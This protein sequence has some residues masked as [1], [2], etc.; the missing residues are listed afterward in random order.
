[1]R[2]KKQREEQK[3]REKGQE[4]SGVESP[5]MG[6][7]AALFAS[8][9]SV[10]DVSL[11]GTESP[12]VR[13][14][15]GLPG[16]AEAA[17]DVEVEVAQ[18]KD[19]SER[20]KDGKPGPESALVSSSPPVAVPA[21]ETETAADEK[22]EPVGAM[23]VDGKMEVATT[24]ADGDVKMDEAQVQSHDAVD[25][26][27][28]LV[29]DRNATPDHSLSAAAHEP[30][31]SA[32][33]PEYASEFN[34]RDVLSPS[35]PTPNG[36]VRHRSPSPDYHRRSRTPPRVLNGYAKTFEA[37]V[38]LLDAVPTGLVAPARED[39]D[40]PVDTRSQRVAS[41][42]P[43]T[44]RTSPKM[45][46][47][48]IPL[49]SH[50]SQEDGEILSPPPPKSLSLAPPR[51]HSPPTHPR[52]FYSSGGLSP[53]RPSPGSLSQSSARAPLHPAYLARNSPASVS[54]LPPPAPPS[55]PRALRQAGGYSGSSYLGSGGQNAPYY[56]PP[57]PRG[58]SADRD[59][60]RDRARDWGRD[61]DRDVDRVWHP[62]PSRG[63]GRGGS[64]R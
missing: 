48:G 40:S 25:H 44:P 61:R 52:H 5:A 55:A 60:D 46:D 41:P 39:T 22:D 20:R 9:S 26:S 21:P 43:V 7:D 51:S 49:V 18:R 47:S 50:P 62:G 58:P 36:H 28:S 33:P 1:M 54:R 37:K 45:S 12:V 16:H 8:P 2:K 29:P 3:V 59:R 15:M 17:M 11:P 57:P 27:D 35:T 42:A 34:R 63:R 10:R 23:E 53:T 31:D 32:R 13:G 19:E 30:S 38:E 14:D 6:G 56:A 4:G 24:D 64:W